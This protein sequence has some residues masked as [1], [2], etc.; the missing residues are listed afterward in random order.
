M[1]KV[2]KG[3]EE[4]ERGGESTTGERGKGGGKEEWTEGRTTERR[5]CG[6]TEEKDND[7][8]HNLVQNTYQ[9][10]SNVC[11]A[12]D[13]DSTRKYSLEFNHCITSPCGSLVI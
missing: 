13:A 12:C 1:R 3:R 5:G 10:L 11:T 9:C 7:K 6:K 4:E 8:F 2:R